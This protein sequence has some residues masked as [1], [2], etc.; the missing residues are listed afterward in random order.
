MMLLPRLLAYS[1]LLGFL[2]FLSLWQLSRLANLPLMV[3]RALFCALGTLILAPMVAPAGVAVVYVPNG[4]IL[5]ILFIAGTPIGEILGDYLELWRFTLPS[6]GITAT[7]FALIAWRLVKADA[8]PLRHRWVALALPAVLLVGIFQVYR[9]VFPDRSI[10]DALNNAVV[11]QAYGPLLDEV[12]NL[13]RIDDP[14]EQR[15]EIARL[16]AAFESDP[17]IRN[18]VLYELGQPV[19][20]QTFS[21]SRERELYLGQSCSNKVETHRNR[22]SR[23]TREY[24]YSPRRDLLGYEHPYDHGGQSWIIDIYLEYD[25]AIDLLLK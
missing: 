2:A 16:K 22:L 7:V 15:A 6:L 14:E 23:C 9:F 19:Q 11:E 24:E 21:F 3:R 13:L 12:G 1:Y 4:L 18:A 10:P 25:D 5:L 17:V 8:K 20:G